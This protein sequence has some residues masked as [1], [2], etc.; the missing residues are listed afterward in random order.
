MDGIGIFITSFKKYY[1]YKGKAMV[2][3]DETSPSFPRM[4]SL[5]QTNARKNEK[6][7]KNLKNQKT[8]KNRVNSKS[9]SYLGKFVYF[10][11]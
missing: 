10:T 5:G 6:I 8:E 11:G 1:N 9:K 7:A 4:C 2:L 3:K